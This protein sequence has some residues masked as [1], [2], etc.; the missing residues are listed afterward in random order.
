[1]S[2][3]AAADRP[4]FPNDRDIE[5]HVYCIFEFPAPGYDPKD[6]AGKDQKIG[7][8]YSSI[9]GNGFGGYGE[10]VYGTGGTLLIEKELEA[11]L[12]RLDA[13]TSKTKVVAGKDRKKDLPSW[14]P[15][16]ARA[17]SPRA[18]SR[19]RPSGAGP[20]GGRARLRGRDRALGLVH[21][22]SRPRPTSHGA[23]PRWPWATR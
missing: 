2:V 17:R 23:A 4:I 3:G 20:A 19:R 9:N 8:E 5:D 10:T 15:T 14:K 6:P 22:Q 18:T 12:Y 13:T 16:P 11:L 21:P 1:M 7:V